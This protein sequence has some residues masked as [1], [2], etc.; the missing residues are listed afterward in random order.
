MS[1]YMPSRNRLPISR[2]ARGKLIQRGRRGGYITKARFSSS[3]CMQS[4]LQPIS[5]RRLMALRACSALT[6]YQRPVRKPLRTSAACQESIPDC[7]SSLRRLS[8]SRAENFSILAFADIVFPLSPLVL[9]D[10]RAKY[11]SLPLTG[12]MK[13]C[14]SSPLLL[15]TKVRT[16]MCIGSV[17]KVNHF[18]L[19][20]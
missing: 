7:R 17:A 3:F 19:F 12:A 18:L 1:W 13:P 6:P 20:V 11:R 9:R 4:R 14:G 5:S 2:E 10:P 8:S 16:G 15:T